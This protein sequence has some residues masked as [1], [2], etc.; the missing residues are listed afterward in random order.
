M[1]GYSGKPL[2]AKLGLKSGQRLLVVDAP[3]HL[4]E[5]LA[6]APEGLVRLARVATFD[7]AWIF[8]TRKPDLARH[9][10]R[11]LPHLADG[12][13]MWVSRPKRASG[14]ATDMTEDEVRAV[15]LPQGLVDIKVCAVD[16]TWSGLK[17]VRRRASR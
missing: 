14:V 17:L 15:V 3:A 9:A 2:A 1:A 13:M 5:L 7:V 10:A 12:G 11:L 16:E 4:D 8:V 6:D